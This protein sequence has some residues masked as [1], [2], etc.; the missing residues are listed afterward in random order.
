MT[1]RV[2]LTLTII[3]ALTVSIDGQHFAIPRS[4]I[5]EI[6]R[7]NGE[8]VTLEHLGGAGVATIRGRRV[9]E[10]SLAKILG[11]ESRVEE[12]DRTLIVL[13]PAGGDLYALSVDRIH[14]HEE[15]VVKPA[16]PVVMATG[17]YAGTTLADDGSPILLFDPA[18]LAQVGGIKLETLERSTRI[19]EGAITVPSKSTAVLLFRA[20]DGSR[21]ALRLAVVDRIEEVAVSSVRKAAGQLR[22]QVGEAILPLTGTSSTELGDGKVRLFRLNDGS[23]EIGYA[24]AE[25][26]DFATIDNDVIH[27]ESPG[28]ISG[29]SLVNGEPAELVDAHW[30]FARHAGA[31]AQ[32]MEQMICRLPSD[33]PWM[34]NMLRPIVEAAGYRVVGDE[35]DDDAD[36]VIAAKGA[37]V[38]DE[39]A[40]KTIWLRTEP[41]AAGKKDDSIYRYDRAGLLMAL[42]TAGAGRGK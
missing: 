22:V 12:K 14:D 21:R 15:L 11:I 5:E 30:L 4:A 41:D 40:K 38:P 26:I 7:A 25:V 27:A 16:A 32:T 2:P 6:V 23:H 20:L 33:D 37:D 10:I 36:L 1:L 3:P 24:F 8:S 9:P 35:Y 28:E 34:Q 17:L 42:K 13:R 19:A 18:G 39:A 31:A 29:V